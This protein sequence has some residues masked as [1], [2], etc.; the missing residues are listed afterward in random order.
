MCKT[1]FCFG[2]KYILYLF[3]FIIHHTI[4][5]PFFSSPPPPLSAPLSLSEADADQKLR[6]F[7]ASADSAP[8]TALSTEI[9]FQMSFF[10][11]SIPRVHILTN[12]RGRTHAHTHCNMFLV[13]SSGSSCSHHLPLTVAVATATFPSSFPLVQ[14]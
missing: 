14:W 7:V 9:S 4:R 1:W 13:T 10:Y 2:G 12:G 11:F 8:W 6:Q 5:T 3:Y